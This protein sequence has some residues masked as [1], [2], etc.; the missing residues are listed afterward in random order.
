MRLL[1]T[2]HGE[3]EENAKRI[4]M[5]S[6]HGKLSKWGGEQA[7]KLAERLKREN[8][9]CIY[10]SDLKRSADTTKEIAKYHPDAPVI[11]TPEL[12][13]RYL[14]DFQGKTDLDCGF[15]I[16]KDKFPQP[17]NGE[18]GKQ[19]VERA[20]KFFNAIL[21]KHKNQ[22]VLIVGHNGI[23]RA[24]IAVITGRTHKD[25]PEIENL[26]T[27]SVCVFEV[28]EKGHKV[29][30]FNCIKHLEQYKNQRHENSGNK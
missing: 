25:M 13:E 18:T 27:T 24:L 30:T 15:D 26:K 22:S 6:L 29:H 9:D 4:L 16:H 14:G 1:I 19:L 11:F 20:K 7:K 8:F 17:P 28:D 21:Q 3:T 23:N 10:S 2:R 5:G 12:R